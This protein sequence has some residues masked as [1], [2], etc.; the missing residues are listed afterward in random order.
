M[1]SDPGG[2][3]DPPAGAAPRRPLG[4]PPTAP[5]DHSPRFIV[6]SGFDQRR[7]TFEEAPYTDLTVR[8]AF[9]GGS[10]KD[11]SDTVNLLRQGVQQHFNDAGHLLPNG[12]QLHVTVEHVGQDG[13]PHLTVD[14]VGP[15]GP[16]NQYSWPV[17][18]HPSEY[19]HEF[20]HQLGLRDEHGDSSSPHQAGIPGS[21]LGDIHQPPAHPGLEQGG[22]RD[23]HLQLIG[24]LTGGDERIYRP[25]SEA[26]GGTSDAGRVPARPA[27]GE[28]AART[29]PQEQAPPREGTAQ[30]GR[31]AAP[32]GAPGRPS[33][34]PPPAA[35]PSESGTISGERSSGGSTVRRPVDTDSGWQRA[36]ASAPWAP[37]SHTWV[38]PVSIPARA[39][40]P[41]ATET[42][43]PT[44]RPA[45]AS[46]SPAQAPTAQ[47][48]QQ[49]AAAEPSARPATTQEPAARP[50][51]TQEPAARPAPEQPAAQKP[52]EQPST[53]HEAAHQ[54]AA[55]P[56]TTQPTGPEATH[57]PTP[58]QPATQKPAGQPAPQP[59]PE[60]PATQQPPSHP[61]A[62]AATTT[63]PINHQQS[64]DDPPAP[65]QAV[66]QPQSAPAPPARPAPA[67]PAPAVDPRHRTSFA[68]LKITAD[69]GP[70]AV[71]GQIEDILGGHRTDTTVVQGLDS[72]LTPGNF[73]DNHP[74]MVDDGWRFPVRVDGRWH[75]VVVT[76]KPGEWLP[77]DHVPTKDQAEKEGKTDI[78][79]A[80]KS[81]YQPEPRKTQA[82][83]SESG[84]NVAPSVT[85]PVN[86][87]LLLT[88]S[89]SLTFGGANHETETTVTSTAE[90]SNKL[91]LTGPTAPHVNQLDYHVTVLDHQGM[92]LGDRGPI[93]DSVTAE[94]PLRGMPEG[95]E[96]QAWNGW[97]RP[98]PGDADHPAPA[99]G[100]HPEGQPLTV[101]GLGDAREA[102][103]TAF[104]AERRPDAAAHQPINDF[105]TSAN[106]VNEFEHASSW[107]MTSPPVR[108]S[109][110]STGHLHLTLEPHGSTVLDTVD[111]KSELG[112]NVSTEHKG[113]QVTKASRSAG[114]SGGPTGQVWKSARPGDHESRWLGGSA[115]YSYTSNHDH[116]DKSS[117]TVKVAD[118]Q[119]HKGKADLVATD[120]RFN[121]S[122]TK[123]HLSP[124]G[125][126]LYVTDRHV[127]DVPGGPGA[128]PAEHHSGDAVIDIDAPVKHQAIRVVP[129]PPAKDTPA[130][131]SHAPAGTSHTPANSSHTP[132]NAPGHS[133]A[134]SGPSGSNTAHA[135]APVDPPAAPAGAAHPVP[136]D[137]AGLRDPLNG[138]RTTFVKVPGSAELAQH[139]V[140]R[141]HETAPGL[142]PPPTGAAG[143]SGSG[144]G[145]HARVTPKA[146]E[147]LAD[148]HRQITPSALARGGP[149]LLDGRFRITLD[150]SHLPG[151]GA[152]T[153]EILIK[154]DPGPGEHVGPQNVT[155]KNSVSRTAGGDLAVTGGGKHTVSGNLSLRTSLN[156]PDTSRAFV[157]GNLEG[158]SST[159]HQTTTAASTE[160]KHEFTIESTAD[161]FGYPVTYHVMTG[162]EEPGHPT[163]VLDTGAG[164]A[165][166]AQTR[167]VAAG[168]QLVV[169]QRPAAPPSDNPPPE[170]PVIDHLPQATFIRDVDNEQAFRAS[171]EKALRSA[172]D[173]GP[174]RRGP[175][176]LTEVLD[177]LGGPGQLRGSVTA[178]HNGW[179][180]SGDEHVGGG[181]NQG[182]AG[183]STRT[184]L[185]D[186]QYQ[187][188]LSGEGK[189]TIEST[190]KTS[191]GVEDKWSR[192]GKGGIGPDFGRFPEAPTGVHESN[193]QL[194]GGFKL[195][196]G[197]TVSGGDAVKHEMSTTRTMATPKGTW[198]VY[199]A[200]AEVTTVGRVTDNKGNTRYGAPERSD[201]TV[202]VLLSDADVRALGGGAEAPGPSD[203]RTAP[204]LDRGISGGA[205]THVPS[206]DE[207]LGEI[208]RQVNGP[209][210]EGAVPTA[211]L[212]F[213]DVYSPHNLDANFDELMTRGIL[214]QHVD[215][216][217][218][219]RVTTTVLVRGVSGAGWHDDHQQS[220]NEIS[221]KV[222]VSQTV[223][224]SA[225]GA[226]SLGAEGNVRASVRPPAAVRHLNNASYNP[227]AGAEGSLTTSA[228]SGITTEVGHKTSGFG[229][230]HKFSNDVG[231][232]VSVS[233]QNH[234]GRFVNLHAPAPVNPPWR[235]QAWVPEP[236]TERPA[237]QHDPAAV[238]PPPGRP[239]HVAQP[240]AGS[241]GA[242]QPPAQPPHAAQ[243][244]APHPAG[245]AAGAPAGGGIALGPV[246]PH[247]ADLSA[248]RK[249]LAAGHDMAGFDNSGQLIDNAIRTL[250]TPRPWGD[251]VVGRTGA[252]LATG[253]GA[254]GSAVSTAAH[255][256][257]PKAAIDMANRV[258]GS[259]IS[260]PR[261]PEGNVLKHEQQQHL[262]PD[263]QQGL[264]QVFS[265]QSTPAIFHELNNH[266]SSYRTVPL[267][268]DGRTGLLVTME[269]TG[270]AQE[271][272]TRENG[273]DELTSSA[274]DASST[275]AT[276]GYTW[277]ANPADFSVL[278]N[279]PLVNVP[280]SLVNLAGQGTGDRTVPVTHAPGVPS[281][282]LPL[283]AIPHG[284]D[285]TEAGK[286]E[287]KGPQS[288][289]RQPVR[290]TTQKT[291]HNGP[292]GEAVPTDGNLYYWSQKPPADEDAPAAA[293][294]APAA[295]PSVP[296]ATAP[297]G[298]PASAPVNTSSS[299]G[300]S[301]RPATPP[302]A[303]PTAS[304]N[305]PA[306]AEGTGG[307][308]TIPPSTGGSSGTP[309]VQGP[310]AV[311]APPAVAGSRPAITLDTS[312]DSSPHP[313][314]APAVPAAQRPTSDAASEVS[315][316]H[317]SVLSDLAGLSPVSP[318]SPAASHHS[319]P[320]SS[321]LD[322]LAAPPAPPASPVPSEPH[323]PAA[324]QPAP[325]PV[326]QPL[327][328]PASQS[329][330]QPPAPASAPLPQPA[331]PPA[332]QPA[333]PSASQPAAQPL[334]QAPAPPASQ[335]LP[336]STAVPAPQ[337][338]SQAT[339]TPNPLSTTASS[340]APRPGPPG[341]AAGSQTGRPP[342]QPAAAR[343]QADTG[344][345]ITTTADAGPAEPPPGEPILS[346]GGSLT[347]AP[348]PLTGG[349]S[350]AVPDDGAPLIAP[351]AAPSP[352]PELPAPAAPK[353]S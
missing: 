249:Q 23:R 299:G 14:L 42:P 291:D 329:P 96:A 280:I 143:A 103:F 166:A 314:P 239:P 13:D 317:G 262:P 59:A 70:A 237:A 122:V 260:D 112:S 234:Q 109:D 202:H 153:H 227:G 110:G 135:V 221:R 117:H 55:Q 45:T 155:T 222:T 319:T 98:P 34:S 248:W 209:R 124:H 148:L 76:A 247:G 236:L 277:S 265:P 78:E 6:R 183:L 189:L 318:V 29:S 93:V 164:S 252:A 133:A 334:S 295:G 19:T 201:H 100:R 163:T 261:L 84:V 279:D 304:Q 213:A 157:N 323:A 301:D 258:V 255:A 179:A 269:P 270:P 154:A 79:A 64:S 35:R 284:K 89:A 106:V 121:V 44:A 344:T 63:T 99:P 125:D 274:K 263:V 130:D 60:Q 328:Q 186:F 170:H 313:G 180:N 283:P 282:T 273:K 286:A 256:V 30:T 173:Q 302:S 215:E 27:P 120:V 25:P 267:G 126:G 138:G 185:G 54:P 94:I 127:I 184:R 91:T 65:E 288:L 11:A 349:P 83:H 80:A 231:F 10:P 140:A 32:A 95:T 199:R 134:D 115:G 259:F 224:G 290:I 198:H 210:P 152:S 241:A 244:Q 176:D 229:S 8:I 102:V 337:P 105:F 17:G 275:A 340:A 251:G 104:P 132:A 194:R 1:A 31:P 82:A 21:L 146:I 197:S 3:S 168:G 187:E 172:F 37:R 297:S 341:P 36:R 20:S 300:S 254:V 278:T 200:N 217:R 326:A 308:V 47:Q 24:A 62:E 285:P 298:A 243:P 223:T 50:A 16:M 129:H 182:T 311:A 90:T 77:V 40:V 336:Q 22:L 28:T 87:H 207:I 9:Q 144:G 167:Q 289:M 108:F 141:L 92:L 294:P 142:L 242:A 264:R 66:A 325:Q 158:S 233:R 101:T 342:Q 235:T 307:P 136:P 250:T 119:E 218:F 351:A 58:E 137:T 181:L 266:G 56:T 145:G 75:E 322:D 33:T 192:A 178:S 49:P 303:E 61:T 268:E 253:A 177:A 5:V 160:T 230:N 159:S 246:G 169:E 238:Q 81:S 312:L 257:T 228:K 324:P 292:Y 211:A 353:G 51:T 305:Q 343:P 107:G 161:R 113:S 68:G 67:P 316:L 71:R 57:Q 296:A 309:A 111:H 208:D 320:G 212:P 188:T 232:D 97:D 335:P 346:A 193:Y 216:N 225:G 85:R 287:L 18:A 271:F 347:L 73:R 352:V 339:A 348:V 281:R 69:P 123:Q 204:L 150:S 306:P 74:Q 206:S 162:R 118:S 293:A 88:G 2:R 276:K 219:G 327:P 86:D 131:S 116:E 26:P 338:A 48:H 226:G 321:V 196:G 331:A 52:A 203:P 171:A 195:K 220:E 72:Q 315:S 38:D 191:T 53:P 128:A 205:F 332:S 350:G 114:L 330:V 190:S 149:D 12:D 46:H 147:N 41:A 175:S 39:E 214:S 310:P 240:P 43:T 151:F 333:A 4:S 15:D 139:I 174:L 272:N 345:P 7:F 156:D 165:H 245:G